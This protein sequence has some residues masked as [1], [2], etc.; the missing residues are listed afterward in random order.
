MSALQQ[1][2]RYA[3]RTFLNSP[4]STAVAIIVL[5]LGI[6]ANAAIFS[7]TSAVLFR[8][9][10]YKDSGSLVFVD[11]N[12][13][14]K[15]LRQLPLSAA[16]FKDF[17]TR[18]QTLDGMGAIRTQSSVLTGGELPERI[19]TAAVS[20]G[21]F[22]ILGMKPALGRSFAPDEDQ[23]DKNRVAILSTGV[24][25]R[26]FGRDPNV[27]GKPLT[28][29]G[30][31]FTV[32]GVAPAQFQFPGS[33]SE[34]WIP[35]TPDP[36]DFLPT[37]RGIHSLRVIARLKPGVSRERAQ[38]ELRIAADQL[39]REYPNS[40]AGFSVD[41]VPLR[42]ELVGDIR[43]TLWMLITAVVA[44][45][46]IACVNV[47]HLLLARA[48][49]REKEIAVRTALGAN[50]GRLVR[51]LLTESVLLAVISGIFGL[52]I[53]YW[54]TWILAKQ[55]PGG[56]AQA[57]EAQL[58]WRV[59]AFTL[60]VSI[61][62]GLAFGLVPALSSARSNL[63]LVLRSGG[64]G[65]TGGRTRSRVRDVLLVGEVACSA[66][67]LIGA[68]LL[69]RSLIRLQEVSPGFRA[70]HVLTMQLSLPP[71]R[72]S[73]L[74]VGL[75]YERLLQRVAALPGVQ[76]AGVCRFL[77]MSGSDAR[78]NF[79]I[80]GQPR[81]SDADQPRAYFRT[82][83]G[84]YFAALGIPL[85]HGR[86]FDGRDNQKTPKVAIVNEI[87]ARR[88]WPGEDPIGKRILSGLDENQWST[89]VGVVGDVRHIGLDAGTDPEMY[90]HYLQI[91]PEAMNLAEGTSALV[92]RTNA[93]PAGMTSSVRRELRALD[94]SLPVFHVQTMQDLLYGSV[95]Q[96]RFRTFLISMFAGLA[97]V[98]ASLGL[99][100]VVAY[101]VSQRTTEL[102][103]RLALG[104][105]PGS[106]LKLVVFRAAGLAVIG[107]AIGIAATLA[108]S[109]V[110]SR[111][112]FGVS[113]SDPITLAITC[114]II[115]LVAVTASLVPALRAAKLD[116]VIAL[117]AE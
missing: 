29:D 43:P 92:I 34:V 54:G 52:L 100:G 21:I 25:Q 90:Y 12:N 88:Y 67:L 94:A 17:L 101:S 58:D 77:P 104:A 63:N 117:R 110:L 76:E 85:I 28:L 41:L 56:L 23:P 78:L 24:W 44:V 15:A 14:T 112:L 13:L 59:L 116:P 19:E 83:S 33:Q 2:L 5:S 74:Q 71:A 84:G 32:V 31:S 107:L 82:A 22:K 9:L 53:A 64:R 20:P 60:G 40:N 70:D 35:Y 26:R 46:L 62:T 79:Q 106:I 1:D 36:K 42:E 4:A 114:V 16:D 10:P 115:L 108:G 39:A 50:P 97:L 6:G 65:G 37:N 102:G 99:Y 81:L 113:T 111:F 68:G 30:G 93:D 49:A 18:N 69:I 95:A 73:G 48:G 45:L 98:L 72:Y 11:E 27:L 51:Q 7:V 38:S 55:A 96:P 3:L 57:G 80:E 89:I 75:F 105:Q 61:V 8:E 109:R 87:A 66:A 103:I 91:P 86:I 47:A